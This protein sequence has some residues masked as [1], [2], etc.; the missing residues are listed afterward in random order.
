MFYKN[1]FMSLITPT[2][3][4]LL[5]SANGLLLECITANLKIYSFLIKTPLLG[6]SAMVLKGFQIIYKPASN[7]FELQPKHIITYILKHI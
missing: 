7:S 2:P 5:L 4:Y 1:S 3:A 6:V